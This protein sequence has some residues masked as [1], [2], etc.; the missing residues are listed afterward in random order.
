MADHPLNLAVRFLLEIAALI[1]LGVW[2]W[3]MHDALAR[4][5]WAIALPSLTAALWGIFRVPND[6]GPAPVAVPGWLRLLLELA[7][8]GGAVI[9][10]WAAGM[11]TAA[12]VMGGLVVAHYLVSYDRVSRLLRG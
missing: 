11:E 7:F 4:W 6:P 1:A 5:L 8:F 3:T 12:L 10:F 9:A 2:G